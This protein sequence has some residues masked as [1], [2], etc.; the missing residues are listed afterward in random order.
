MLMTG[1]GAPVW[2]AW[3]LLA[4]ALIRMAGSRPSVDPRFWDGILLESAAFL[5]LSFYCS[6][7]PG[8]RAAGFVLGM[9]SGVL[10]YIWWTRRRKRRRR[11]CKLIGDK[12]RA[13]LAAIVRTMRETTKPQRVLRPVPQGGGA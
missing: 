7:I 5:V 9:I 13:L 6:H 10:A 8:L 11:V 4:L 2:I 1:V 3:G 12:S